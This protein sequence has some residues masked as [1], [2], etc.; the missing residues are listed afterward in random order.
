MVGILAAVAEMER[1]QIAERTRAGLEGA[2]ARGVR[3][4]RPIAKVPAKHLR[5]IIAGRK[6]AADVARELGLSDRTVRA[7]VKEKNGG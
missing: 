5:A 1:D 6:T 2:R 7:R 3:L 4:G